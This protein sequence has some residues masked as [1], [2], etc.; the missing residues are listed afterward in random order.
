MSIDDGKTNRGYQ[1]PNQGN[2]LID[3]VGRLRAALQAIDAD[4]YARYTKIEVD[5]LI[6]NLIQGAPGALDTLNELAA[7]LG[8]DANFAATVASQL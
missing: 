7:A 6:A 4:I 5:T 2:F 3:Y 1:L 8:D